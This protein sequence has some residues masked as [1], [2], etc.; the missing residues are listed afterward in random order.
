MD[1]DG[2]FG[3]REEMIARYKKLELLADSAQDNNKRLIEDIKQ[4]RSIALEHYLHRYWGEY[5]TITHTVQLLIQH[6]EM[7]QARLNKIA[8]KA[9]AYRNC[10]NPV[11]RQRC[12]KELFAALSQG[13]KDG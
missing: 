3:N 6:F 12:R 7:E 10:R 1:E 4:A 9:E 5:G 13:G 11:A 2:C 8:E